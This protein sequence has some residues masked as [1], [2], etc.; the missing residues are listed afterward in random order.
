MVETVCLSENWVSTK[1]PKVAQVAKF[2][3]IWSPCPQISDKLSAYYDTELITDVK[4]FTGL[5]L[6]KV[7]TKFIL[8]LIREGC[9]ITK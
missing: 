8:A 6:S 1:L 7:L 3:P 2:H 5:A 4:S 9:L